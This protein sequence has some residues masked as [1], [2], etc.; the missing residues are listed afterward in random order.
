MVVTI[1]DFALPEHN[2]I[3]GRI[4][5][6]SNNE[7]TYVV[8]CQMP[9]DN[10]AIMEYVEKMWLRLLYKGDS[11]LCTPIIYLIYMGH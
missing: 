3:E 9:E 8:G 4:I 5:R 1:D 6:S 2:V 7:G 10:Y 11:N